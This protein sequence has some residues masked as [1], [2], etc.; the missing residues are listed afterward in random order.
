MKMGVDRIYVVQ[1]VSSGG[2]LWTRNR[3]FGS[4][5]NVGIFCVSHFGIYSIPWDCFIGLS[6]SLNSVC[7]NG[8]WWTETRECNI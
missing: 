4:T 5:W 2:L 6:F 3:I 7:K 1:L 8:W